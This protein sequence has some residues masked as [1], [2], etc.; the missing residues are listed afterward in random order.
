[1][2]P[3]VLRPYS[4]EI[5]YS[6]L[7]RTA[8]VYGVDHSGGSCADPVGRTSHPSRKPWVQVSDRTDQNSCASFT[9]KRRATPLANEQTLDYYR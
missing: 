4:G 9:C 8:A 1:M 7:A 3:V 5:L 6:W 2:V